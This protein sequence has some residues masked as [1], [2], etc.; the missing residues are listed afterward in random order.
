MSQLKSALRISKKLHSETAKI[1][2][3]HQNR[4]SF[5]FYTACLHSIYKKA[6]ESIKMT[7]TMF[8]FHS[9]RQKIH[10]YK[11]N[12]LMYFL[13]ALFFIGL[14]LGSFSVKNSDSIIIQKIN[15]LYMTYLNSKYTLSSFSIF[16]NTLL[17]VSVAVIFSFFTGL[18]AIG[19]PFVALIPA[20]CGALIGIVSGYVYETFLLKGLG[21]CAIIIFPTAAIS[22]SAI[23]FS[24][25]ESMMMSRT[26]LSLLIKGRN[27]AEQSFRNYCIRFLIYILITVFAALTET[28]L[29]NLFIG[30]FNFQAV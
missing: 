24:C 15:E 13:V 16:L 17:L 22:V 3:D 7:S 14:I 20:V 5:A 6:G 4:W 12:W 1:L 29:T 10:S 8:N 28:V 27:Q 23:L 19:V 26:M 11:F 30:L 9:V 21:Y 2:N 25:K 18:C